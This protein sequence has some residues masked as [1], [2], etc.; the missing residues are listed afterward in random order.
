MQCSAVFG[1]S[2][3]GLGSQVLHVHVPGYSSSCLV[4]GEGYPLAP[5]AKGALQAQ[6]C[7]KSDGVWQ[8]STLCLC[9]AA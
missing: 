5:G 9:S 3:R 4:T 2:A 6:P 7:P 8:V 1:R